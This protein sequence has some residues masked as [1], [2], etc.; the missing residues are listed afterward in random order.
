MPEIE[1]FLRD[2]GGISYDNEVMSDLDAEDFFDPASV[3]WYRRL[4]QEKQANRHADLGDVEFLNEWGFVVE[5]DRNLRPTRASVL[6]FGKA[7]L[8]RS[9]WPRGVV[10]YQRI[11]MPFDQWSPERRWSDRVVLEENIIQAW[12]LLIEKYFRFAER[13]FS[14]DAATLR[15]HDE[16]PDYI[17]FRE[18]AINA[19]GFAT[20]S[21]TFLV[22]VGR[23]LHLMEYWT[24]F[25][26]T[27][28]FVTFAV[29]NV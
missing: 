3:A 8:L 12:Q 24:P 22:V 15:R 27:V 9:L 1:R 20:V 11:D 29:N 6:L 2:A 7:R 10:D 28:F 23:T 26:F 13:P 25:F 19:T 16:P 14:V 5:K 4:L 18:A 21:I 17:P